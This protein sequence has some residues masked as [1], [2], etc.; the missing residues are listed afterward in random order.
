M[1]ASRP[2]LTFRLAQSG[3]FEAVVKLSEGIYDGHD[4]LPLEFH[5]WLQRENLAVLL[6]Y[7]D[8]KLVGF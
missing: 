6:A 7:S 1:D 2:E 3:D 8:D 4:Y 5:K